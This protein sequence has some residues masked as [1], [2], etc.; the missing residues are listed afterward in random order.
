MSQCCLCC[1]VHLKYF[2]G[3]LEP[4]YVD[5]NIEN[6]GVLNFFLFMYIKQS[7]SNFYFVNCH[8]SLIIRVFQNLLQLTN[9]KNMKVD[10][11][12]KFLRIPLKLL[13]HLF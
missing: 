2:A 4:I 12:F 11:L 13:L 8:F 6:I 10:A 3:E 5:K 1:I 9:I 7:A